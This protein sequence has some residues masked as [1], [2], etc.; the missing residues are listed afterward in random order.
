M[1]STV[2]NVFCTLTGGYS[3]NRLKKKKKN[4]KK[5][6]VVIPMGI[7]VPRGGVMMKAGVH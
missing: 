5:L 4:E 7:K 3:K 6:L 2:F 1:I